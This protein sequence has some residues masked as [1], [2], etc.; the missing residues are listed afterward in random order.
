MVTI[1]IRRPPMA[2]RATISEVAVWWLVEQGT[3]LS[4]VQLCHSLA[5]A[6]NAFPSVRLRPQVEPDLG[7]ASA[8]T[9]ACACQSSSGSLSVPPSQAFA[10]GGRCQVEAI[11]SKQAGGPGSL[12][13]I[14]EVARVGAVDVQ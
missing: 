6:Q 13:D 2:S 8:K 12:A 10:T 11:L 14:G 3:G 9:Q 5:G 7:V 4:T 1:Q